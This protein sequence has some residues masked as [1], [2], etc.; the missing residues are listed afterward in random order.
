MRRRR[1]SGR[2]RRSS[3]GDRREHDLAPSSSA[4][5]RRCAFPAEQ[6]RRR[7]GTARK[8]RRRPRAWPAA[9]VA[10]GTASSKSKAAAHAG[11][12]LTSP[13]LRGARAPRR[14]HLLR[15]AR[16]RGGRRP[17]PGGH[18][19]HDARS[20]A[21]GGGTPARAVRATG[22]SGSSQRRAPTVGRH[23]LTA[24]GR[25]RALVGRV[26]GGSSARRSARPATC[27]RTAVRE[28]AQLT[29]TPSA[30]PGATQIPPR[31]AISSHAPLR[32]VVMTR[33]PSTAP[34][35]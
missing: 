21:S 24:R 15:A 25:R 14:P 7:R 31:I 13:T 34:R 9:A 2:G 16:P 4:S 8:R 17:G 10:N 18:L 12:S 6:R 28:H 20:F 19:E 33:Q 29:A 5:E 11:G 27:S 35:A 26:T 23:F 22:P 32:G 30:S 1:G 3:H